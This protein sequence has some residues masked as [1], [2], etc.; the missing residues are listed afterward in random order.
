MEVQ[1]QDSGVGISEE[2]QEKLFKMFGFLNS[3][4]QMNTQG[5]GLGLYICKQIV[6]EFD[7]KI[8]VKS[9]PQVGSAFTFSMMMPK[10]EDNPPKLESD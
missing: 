2:D 6:E 5:I 8:Y 1:V 3:T 7:G 10:H 4:Q 9:V